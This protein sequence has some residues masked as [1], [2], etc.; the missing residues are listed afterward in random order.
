MRRFAVVAAIV[1]AVAVMVAA[2]AHAQ[3]RDYVDVDASV[4]VIDNLQ[5]LDDVNF[6]FDDVFFESLFN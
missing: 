2:P 1:T 3:D 4:E 6:E 5:L